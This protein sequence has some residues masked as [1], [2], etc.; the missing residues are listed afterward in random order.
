M[1]LPVAVLPEP[2]RVGFRESV[3]HCVGSVN[4]VSPV[5][6]VE[7]DTGHRENGLL[8][9]MNYSVVLGG[10]HLVRTHTGGGV[11]RTHTGGGGSPKYM[12]I[13]FTGG[14]GWWWRGGTPLW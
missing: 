7:L 9:K 8:C 6:R 1:S 10:M 4:Q 5:L 2:S 13:S 12:Q 3:G 11:V 14:Q